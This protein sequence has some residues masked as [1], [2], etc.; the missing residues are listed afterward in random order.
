METVDALKSK[1]LQ[2]RLE[3]GNKSDCW[4]TFRRFLECILF[5]ASG[6]DHLS[7]SNSPIWVGT[8]FCVDVGAFH[9]E[10]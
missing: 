9:Y 6:S 10:G 5:S 2:I 4:V 8:A 3:L 7:G 1:L